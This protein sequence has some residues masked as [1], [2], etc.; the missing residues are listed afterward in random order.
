MIITAIL[1]TCPVGQRLQPRLFLYIIYRRHTHFTF[2]QIQR[3]FKTDLVLIEQLAGILHH[4]SLLSAATFLLF[5]PGV[6]R[7]LLAE[8]REHQRE[9]E[10]GSERGNA[11][12]EG[13]VVEEEAE[14]VFVV[15]EV[16][17]FVFKQMR[18]WG[19]CNVEN[20]VMLE[21]K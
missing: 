10:E 16:V 19:T 12:E 21:G 20:E 5:D 3:K 18:E 15:L 13:E 1:N 7:P 11:Q 6:S 14:F 8:E 17:Q 4:L 2:S 9:D